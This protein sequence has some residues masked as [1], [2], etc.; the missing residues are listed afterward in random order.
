M[1]RFCVLKVIL[2]SLIILNCFA[3]QAYFKAE[4]VP[5]LNYYPDCEYKVIDTH[6]GDYKTEQRFLYETREQ[7]LKEIKKEA[8]VNGAEAIIILDL[9]IKQR[10]KSSRGLA[11]RSKYSSLYD[12]KYV[13]EL[14]ELCGNKK[15]S[16]KQTPFNS[17]L[18]RQLANSSKKINMSVKVKLPAKEKLYRP[19][20]TDAVISLEYGIYGMPL[21][22]NLED[23]LAAFGD[24]SVELNSQRGEYIIAYGRK[25]WLYFQDSQLVKVESIS[26]VLSVEILNKVPMLDFFDDEEWK[27]LGKYSKN[28]DLVDMG[29]KPES[30]NKKQQFVISNDKATLVMQ[31][32]YERD[33]ETRKKRYSLAGFSLKKNTYDKTDN[34]ISSVNGEHFEILK[35]LYDEGALT[36]E[37]S[38]SKLLAE[39]GSPLGRIILGQN[40]YINIYNDNLFLK[41]KGDLVQHVGLIEHSFA[42]KGLR[43]TSPEPWYLSEFTQ[44]ASLNKLRPLFSG[45]AFELG[46]MVEI[47]TDSYQLSLYFDDEVENEPLYEAKLVF[48]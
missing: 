3:A 41:A 31:F 9:K 21:G 17:Q 45:D 24:P 26:P 32:H 42:D 47:N 14:I 15:L 23:I 8:I 25:H 38:Q 36:D 35:K 33:L 10:F 13:T 2:S 44:G 1:A 11:N 20:I 34:V 18:Q 6:V 46:N 48:H 4:L 30:L 37:Y 40:T 43:E 5:I 39:M 19:K 12:I 16:T 7:V 27:V 28:T 22:T 29:I